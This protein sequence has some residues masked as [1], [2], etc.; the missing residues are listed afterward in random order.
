VSAFVVR[1]RFLRCNKSVNRSLI[2]LRFRRSVRRW[3]QRLKLS[4]HLLRDLL[5]QQGRKRRRIKNA[6]VALAHLCKRARPTMRSAKVNANSCPLVCLTTK[7]A[8]I[9]HVLRRLRRISR[10]PW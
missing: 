5:R 1:D 9:S 6:E 10:T 4:G 7:C 2:C 8:V 3:K